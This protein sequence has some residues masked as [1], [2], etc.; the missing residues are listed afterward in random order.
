M[1][2]GCI[3]VLEK[4]K[5][6][7]D[8]WGVWSFVDIWYDYFWI[9]YFGFWIVIDYVV[10]VF[11]VVSCNLVK[12]GKCLGDNWDGCGVVLLLNGML[13]YCRSMFGVWVL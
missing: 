3:V 1:C 7:G 13:K 8:G 10:L 5:K 12:E 9:D 11:D 4:S 6:L 2:F